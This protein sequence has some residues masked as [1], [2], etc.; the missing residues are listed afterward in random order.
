MYA[1][2]Q[3]QDIIV[4]CK[5]PTAEKM[6]LVSNTNYDISKQIA[7]VIRQQHLAN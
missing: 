5:N 3:V 7:P 1:T 6:V 2:F 4:S